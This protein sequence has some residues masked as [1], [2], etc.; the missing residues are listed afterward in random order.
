M[1]LHIFI[2][3][4]RSRR[5][6][7]CRYYIGINKCYFFARLSLAKLDKNESRFTVVAKVLFFARSDLAN[8]ENVVRY[9]FLGVS[10]GVDRVDE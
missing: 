7:S 10:F 1:C 2:S 3:K 6:Y 9:V 4:R 8:N 5:R